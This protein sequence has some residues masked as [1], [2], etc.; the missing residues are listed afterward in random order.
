M[1]SSCPHLQWNSSSGGRLAPPLWVP[2]PWGMPS[3]ALRSWRPPLM[4]SCTTYG[5]PAP[6]DLTWY[7]CFSS[8]LDV[9]TH[10]QCEEA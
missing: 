6:E 3:P 7:T 10:K 4:G 1:C 9:L 2:A 8:I 5:L